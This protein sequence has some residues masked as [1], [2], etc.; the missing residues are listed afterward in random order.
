MHYS[1]K[2]IPSHKTTRELPE[3]LKQS[4]SQEIVKPVP[5]FEHL[6]RGREKF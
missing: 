4:H 2:I 6:S 5:L 3:E 1:K